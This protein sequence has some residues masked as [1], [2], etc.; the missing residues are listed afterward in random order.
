MSFFVIGWRRAVRK[1]P[2]LL[3][4]FP[5]SLCRAWISACIYAKN[6]D[7]KGHLTWEV[8][9]FLFLPSGAS[10]AMLF[11]RTL[12]ITLFSLNRIGTGYKCRI[13]AFNSNENPPLIVMTMGVASNNIL[14]GSVC[15]TP[16]QL[17]RANSSTPTII[18]AILHI[19]KFFFAAMC[20]LNWSIFCSW[21]AS[22][23]R[24]R[25]CRR[26]L[27]PHPYLSQLHCSQSPV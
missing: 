27:G 5:V 21:S 13:T 25:V 23:M 1:S 4:V 12:K 3:T 26:Y 8:I 24:S 16:N 18:A 6:R 17:R 7:L 19:F 14:M 11:C 20:S 10:G 15:I 9:I 22:L 2:E